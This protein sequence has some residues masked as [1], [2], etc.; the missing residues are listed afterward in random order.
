MW[1]ANGERRVKGRVVGGHSTWTGPA[2]RA[3]KQGTP[4]AVSE[5]FYTFV[6][7]GSYILAAPHQI[8]AANAQGAEIELVK[9]GPKAGSI[10][11]HNGA[12]KGWETRRARLAAATKRE[13][14]LVAE[15][16][17]GQRIHR[18]IGPYSTVAPRAA[19]IREALSSLGVGYSE[20]LAV[21]E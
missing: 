7:H 15:F 6:P 4:L 18:L 9:R 8:E 21:S 2:P 5:G 20:S 1:L 10:A 11:A 12:I 13:P 3:A 16:Q 14:R 19:A 17:C